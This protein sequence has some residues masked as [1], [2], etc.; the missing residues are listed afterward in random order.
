M[1]RLQSTQATDDFARAEAALDRRRDTGLT[2][3]TIRVCLGWYYQT[4]AKLSCPMSSRLNTATAPNGEEVLVE[5]TMGGRGSSL[6][7]VHATLLTVN[8]ALNALQREMPTAA[9]I[10]VAAHRD[11]KSQDKIAQDLHIGQATVSK[12]LA[13]AEAYLLGILRQ[14]GGVIS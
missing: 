13:V 7:E 3:R 14:K 9:E 2:F 6:E 8:A 4:K 11:G 1:R 10:L 5:A 12:E